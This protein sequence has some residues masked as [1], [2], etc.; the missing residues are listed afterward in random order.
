MR[1]FQSLKFLVPQSIRK[2]ISYIRRRVRFSFHWTMIILG[3]VPKGNKV[4]ISY[5]H[6]HILQSD[7]IV[8]GGM[9]K[10]QRIQQFFPNSPRRFNVLY[11][12]SSS[13]PKDWRQQVWLARHKKAFFLYNQNGVAFPAWH[14]PGWNEF[15]RPMAELINTADY[16]FYQ[17]RFCK[18]SADR[19]LEERQGPWEIL[20]N[21]VDSNFF[22]PTKVDPEPNQLVLLLGGKQYQYYPLET[23]FRTLALIVRERKDVRLLVTGRLTWIT[24]EAETNRIA[25]HLI[26]E[27][28]ITDHIEFLGSYEQREAPAVF[29]RAHLLLHTKV[30]DPCPSTVIEAMACGLPVVYSHS[31]GVPELVGRDAGIGISTP[32]DWEQIH[33]PDP[34]QLADAILR[35]AEQRSVY[36]EAARQRAVEKFDLQPWLQRHIEVIEQLSQPNKAFTP[37]LKCDQNQLVMGKI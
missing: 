36:A 26:R 11:L 20:Y 17:S 15:N 30:N 21:A 3:G 7:S 24:D 16:V 8:W 28:A 35:V 27:L 34:Q 2:A 22:T 31:G 9:V 5:G 14:G 13:L 23:A 1:I 32:L 4:A 25:Q 10:F 19:F 6:N 37:N 33:A 12:G 18:M 29:R